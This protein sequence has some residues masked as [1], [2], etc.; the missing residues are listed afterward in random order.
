G[1]GERLRLLTAAT[2]HERI[3]ALQAHDATGG[4]A[5]VDEHLV[6]LVLREIDVAGR[7][8]GG[9][10]LG[11][12]GRQRQEERR[13]QAVVDHHVGP[14]EQHRAPVREQ[15]R[16]TRPGA[17]EVDGHAAPSSRSGLSSSSER[18]PRAISSAATAR[19]ATTG[20]VSRADARNTTWP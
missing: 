4:P 3:A 16:I 9:D 12:L 14:A 5:P 20:S 1:R 8:A 2:E 17:H 6:D 10:E 11:T 13:R 15:P 19:P 7:L 18:P